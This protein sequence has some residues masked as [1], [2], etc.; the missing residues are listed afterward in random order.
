MS[1]E[2]WWLV[3]YDDELIEL[4]TGPEPK[5]FPVACKREW[6]FRLLVE[7][8][9]LLH[10]SHWCGFSPV[11]TRWCFWRWASWVKLFVQMSHW[12]GRSPVDWMRFEGWLKYELVDVDVDLELYWIN[13]WSYAQV[14]R[15][16]VS[17]RNQIKSNQMKSNEFKWNQTKSNQVKSSRAIWLDIEI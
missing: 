17:Q 15:C 2:C 3:E 14:A 4:L 13:P 10:T 12:K 16:T 5:P 1:V 11:W 8:K 6:V 9:R 7:L